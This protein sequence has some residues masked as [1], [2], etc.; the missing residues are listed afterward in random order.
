MRDDFRESPRSSPSIRFT[1]R[2][3]YEWE[4]GQVS[5]ATASISPPSKLS[6]A[7]LDNSLRHQ[8]AC[9]G[10][11]VVISAALETMRG[12]CVQAVALGGLADGNRIEPRRLDQNIFRLLGDHRV[13]AAHDSGERD[14]LFGIGDDQVFRR[15][16]AVNAIERLQ[17]FAFRA[18]GAR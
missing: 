15:K 2:S 10:C 4:P 9:D 16:F 18:R 6:A 3:Q 14:G 7:G 13:E 8:R 17:R 12:V 11:C 5:R 1:L